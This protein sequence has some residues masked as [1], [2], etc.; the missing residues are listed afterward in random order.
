[1]AKADFINPHI[2]SGLK[3]APIEY[4][5][6]ETLK[7]KKPE[8]IEAFVYLR[9]LD[10]TFLDLSIFFNKSLRHDESKGYEFHLLTPY[11]KLFCNSL[12][13]FLLFFHHQFQKLF[14]L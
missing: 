13:K 9:I 8:K 12:R 6:R 10:Y 5:Y 1:L 11:D 14:F 3:S 7:R 2:E 4:S